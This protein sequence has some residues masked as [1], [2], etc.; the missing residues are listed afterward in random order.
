MEAQVPGP[1]AEEVKRD[2]AAVEFE[3]LVRHDATVAR[4]E[5]IYRMQRLRGSE[6]TWRSV[7]EALRRMKERKLR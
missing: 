3:R 2:P 6:R 7:R 4:V 5:A 1:E